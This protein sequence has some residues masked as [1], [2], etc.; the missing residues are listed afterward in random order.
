MKAT[1][2]IVAVLAV[3]AIGIHAQQLSMNHHHIRICCLFVGFHVL[4]LLPFGT[5][6]NSTSS[7]WRI[8]E[9]FGCYVSK[10]NRC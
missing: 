6:F 9:E 8:K 4:F 2:I 1:I 5:N 10:L 7:Y 3:L